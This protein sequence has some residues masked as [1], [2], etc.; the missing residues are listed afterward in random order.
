MMEVGDTAD[1]AVVVPVYNGE[2]YIAEALQ[3]ALSQTIRPAEILVFDNGSTDKTVEIATR[4][5]PAEAVRTSP[6]NVGAVGNFNRAVRE[7]SGDYVLWLAADDRLLPEHL[8]LC[9]RA[10]VDRPTARACLPGIRFIDEAGQPIR[11]QSDGDLGAEDP[12]RRLRSFVRRGRWTESYCLYRREALL[13]SPM[14]T[15]DYATDVLLTWWFLLRGPLTVVLEPLL[16]YREYSTKTVDEMAKSL[17]PDAPDQQWRKVKL[18]RLMWKAS[19][20]EDV[21]S[22]TGSIARQELLLCLPHRHWVGH[23]AEDVRLYFASVARRRSPI[24]T[25]LS[26]IL[27]A[28]ERLATRARSRRPPPDNA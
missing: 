27:K 23:F 5:V 9:L 17:D 14:F 24:A 13:A 1:V 21:G 2:R 11:D 16:E 3:S 19:F 28:V 22:G 15:H 7:S 8:E 4:I 18:W 10:L 20:A 12:R 25:P 26:L 6:R